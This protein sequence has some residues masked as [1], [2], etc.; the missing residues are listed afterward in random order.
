MGST[1][2]LILKDYA[3]DEELKC[4]RCFLQLHSCWARY[5][6]SLEGDGPESRNPFTC[7]ITSCLFTSSSSIDDRM[8]DNEKI[9]LIKKYRNQMGITKFTK[10]LTKRLLPISAIQLRSSIL[11]FCIVVCLPDGELVFDSKWMYTRTVPNNR[12]D[13]VASRCERS[14]FLCRFMCIVAKWMGSNNCGTMKLDWNILA[15]LVPVLSCFFSAPFNFHA[16]NMKMRN[17]ICNESIS[18]KIVMEIIKYAF[19]TSSHRIAFN[20]RTFLC[21]SNLVFEYFVL[22]ESIFVAEAKFFHFLS[23]SHYWRF[24]FLLCSG[25]QQENVCYLFNWR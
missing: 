9:E 17:Q 22:V 15:P 21:I 5:K 23:K 4:M 11:F 6:W 12:I 8:R 14:Y 25:V 16:F 18:V 19:E 3:S 7:S 20:V 2:D 13:F 1:F 10:L 24:D